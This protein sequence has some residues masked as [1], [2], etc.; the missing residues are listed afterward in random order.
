LAWNNGLLAASSYISFLFEG[1][2]AGRYDTSGMEYVYWCFGSMFIALRG[3]I[4]NLVVSGELGQKST[5]SDGS[6]CFYRGRV[7]IICC[8]QTYYQQ[9]VDGVF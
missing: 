8:W 5:E 9:L 3:C 6:M 4:K 2:I 7:L 1:Y